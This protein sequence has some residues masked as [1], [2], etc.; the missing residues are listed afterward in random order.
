MESSLLLSNITCI[1]HAAVYPE[2]QII[3]GGSFMLS[4]LVLGPVTDDESVVIDFS[5]VKKDIKAWTD[6]PEGLDHKLWVPRERVA[7][8]GEEQRSDEKP[9]GMSLDTGRTAKNAIVF[10]DNF[11]INMPSCRLAFVGKELVGET[12]LGDNYRAAAQT[13]LRDLFDRKCAEKYPGVRIL[14]SLSESPVRTPLVPCLG[15]DTPTLTEYAMFRYVHGLKDSTSWG[16]N[17]IA[18]GHLSYLELHYLRP[19]STPEAHHRSVMQLTK[20]ICDALDGTVFINKRNIVLRNDAGHLLEYV[21]GHGAA[22]LAE[23]FR[24]TFRG[25]PGQQAKVLET[26]T[27]VEYLAEYVAAT[28]AKEFKDWG[29]VGFVISEGLTKGA[30]RRV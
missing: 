3:Q 15:M 22:E 28:Y 24:A 1:D 6:G 9:I 27:T 2:Q 21:V 16:C 11:T 14:P 23:H 10:A 29:I 8:L 12:L 30:L 18:H 19:L 17:N 26:E 25:A 7:N 5:T 4:C 13:Y 20:K